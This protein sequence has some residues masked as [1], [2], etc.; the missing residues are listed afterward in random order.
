MSKFKELIVKPW[1]YV[2]VLVIGISFK[3]YHVDYRY[4]WLDEISTVEQTSGLNREAFDQF[5]PVNEIASLTYY[6]SL[7]HLNDLDLTVA[8]QL[9]G[10]AH[11]MNLN[12]LHYFLLTF[13][14]RLVGDSTYALR[15]FSV[16]IFLLTLPF[17][18][19]LAK[20]LFGDNL[21]GWIAVSLFSVMQYAQYYSH[22][23]R[24]IT[25]TIFLIVASSY[26][27]LEALDRKK[28]W[29]WLGY[30]ISGALALYASV[31][32]G[33][34]FIAHFLFVIFF[35]K[36][37][38]FQFFVSISVIFLLYLPWLLFI[39]RSYG[40]VEEALSWQKL[41]NDNYNFLLLIFFQL[42][43]LAFGFIELEDPFVLFYEKH[44]QSFSTLIYLLLV[45]FII[46]SIFYAARKMRKES[47]YFLLLMLLCSFLFFFSSD[48]IRHAGSS[49]LL[50][51]HYMNVVAA[52]FF[53][54]FLLGRKINR[55][56]IF[57][58][59]IYIAIAAL[60]IISMQEISKSKTWAYHP[61]YDFKPV[62]Y[63]TDS[64]NFLIISDFITP[65]DNGITAFLMIANAI[66]SEN[67]EVL[68]TTPDNPDIKEMA[69]GKNYSDIFVIYA[70]KQLLYNLKA[71]FGDRLTR[72][73]DPE[74]YN[75]F[76][77]I[78]L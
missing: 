29:W 36:K 24:Y 39:I 43:L 12:P 48:L 38:F 56:N 50:R 78:H 59:A 22:E 70:S 73:D 49:L 63:M 23:A 69:N 15:F 64:E 53:I 16:F 65:F 62:D 28:F 1:I 9:K 30:I 77:H 55:K 2:L 42:S 19:L 60:G 27:L 72:I 8:Q 32:L 47:F 37:D 41:F 5:A 61:S 11:T 20:K 46:V 75:R 10:Q 57:Y 17:I 6:K 4:F 66:E 31:I 25:L 34:L 3:F 13:W 67:V 21:S 51:Y 45:V 44:L 54:T 40:T 14:H 26:F 58:F 33:L 52:L 68:R 74:L 7:V 76:Y 71:Q 18:F 35:R